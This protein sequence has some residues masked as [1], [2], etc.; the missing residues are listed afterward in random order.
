MKRCLLIGLVAVTGLAAW[1]VNRLETCWLR[2]QQSHEEEQR[3]A[4]VEDWEVHFDQEMKEMTDRGLELARKVEHQ[5][6]KVEKS[7]LELDALRTKEA[8]FDALIRDFVARTK[9][10]ESQVAGTRITFA[11]A[12]RTFTTDQASIQLD[13]Y[14]K[15][16]QSLRTRADH[17][18]ALHIAQSEV[19]VGLEAAQREFQDRY[20]ELQIKREEYALELELLAVRSEI[21]EARN[22]AAQIRDAGRSSVREE[23]FALGQILDDAILE[24]KAEMNVVGRE[25]L[26][27]GSIL[28]LSQ[29]ANRIEQS[30]QEESI[31]AL[32]RAYWNAD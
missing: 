7:R 25:R 27:E 22:N 28:S 17:L 2:I 30:D 31:D 8:R 12:G 21:Q 23:M 18:E 19:I 13:G 14:L 4:L 5:K 11:F 24:K 1:N 15:E 16:I 6:V 29:T 32:R 26:E 9:N 10:A 3:A 20:Q